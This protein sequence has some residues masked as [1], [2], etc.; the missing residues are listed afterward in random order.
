M[1]NILD[2]NLPDD[3]G[4]PPS[5]RGELEIGLLFDPGVC[6]AADARRLRQAAIAAARYR[7]CDRGQLGI[8][9]TDDATICELNRRHLGH[10][11][12][13]DVISFGYA[14]EPPRV[15]GELVVSDTTARREAARRG[16]EAADELVLYA[17]HGVLHVTGMEDAEPQD[18]RA[19][20]QAEREILRELGF[21][22]IHR[23]DV[24]APS[25]ADAETEAA[26]GG[27]AAAVLP[28]APSDV[29]PESIRHRGGRQL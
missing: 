24:D 17:V 15:E 3:D 5:P 25:A 18:R 13:T 12:A 9:V 26:S 22:D 14:Y 6:P 27:G 28:P 10:P 23:W 19:M 4:E 7:G 8:R 1:S 16:L 21:P 2:S 11:Y 20:R 29:K